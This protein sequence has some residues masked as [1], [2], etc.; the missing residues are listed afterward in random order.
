M[1]P[2]ASRPG[3]GQPAIARR[4]LLAAL[5]ALPLAIPC[6]ALATSGAIDDAAQRPLAGLKRWGSG[7]FRRFG[8]T[9]YQ[10]TLWAGDDPQ[11]PPLALHLIYRRAIAGTTIAAASIDEIRRLGLADA[12]TLQR[13]GALLAELFPDV[14]GGDAITG[15][16]LPGSAR[17]DFNGRTLG[18]IDDAQF[19]HAFFAIWLDART[20]A[21]EL[22]AALLGTAA[23]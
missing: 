21:P 8:L 1:P 15:L 5:A 22:R 7:E 19:A 17:F 23:G 16:Y 2:T 9:L 14:V 12:A 10:A 13:W 20:R 4:R 6:T 11:R 18:A 3:G